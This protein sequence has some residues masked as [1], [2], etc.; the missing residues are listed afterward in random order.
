[1]AVSPSIE[2]VTATDAAEAASAQD[3]VLVRRAQ[4]GDVEAFGELVERN[5]RAVFRAALAA[6][7]SATEADDVAQEAFVTAFQKLNGFRAESSFKTWLLTIT[8]RKAIDRRKSV[9][10]WMHRLVAPAHSSETGEEWDPM[11]RLAAGGQSQ[12]DELMTS[13]LQKRL[14]PLIASL[15]K[16]LRD[17]LLLAGSG[18]HT[19]DEIAKLLKIPTGTVK[20]RVSEARKVL[21]QKMLSIGYTDV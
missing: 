4:A 7:G 20:W 19:Y 13:D 16:K 1:M 12:E 11:E 18:D 5:R 17:A 10:K 8:W 15:P 2:R 14:R 6:V 3:L 9:T 21:K